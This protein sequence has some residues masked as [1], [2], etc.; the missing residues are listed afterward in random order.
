MSTQDQPEA[1]PTAGRRRR[2]LI[3]VAVVLLAPVL[4]TVGVLA[5]LNERSGV[6]SGLQTGD[7]AAVN[8]IEVQATVQKVDAATRFAQLRVEVIPHGVY[9]DGASAIPVKA[10]HLYTSSPTRGQLTFPAGQA[11]AAQDVTIGLFDGTF[12]DYPFDR[13]TA[14]IAF[15][16]DADGVTAPV[17]VVVDDIDPFFR[18]RAKKPVNEQ[19]VAGIDERVKR[20][21]GTVLL[22]VFMMVAMWA[23]ALAVAG[24]AW[25]LVSQRRGLVWPALG[26]MAATLFALVGMRNA[27]PGNPPVGCL[28]DYAAFFWAELL[29]AVSVVAVAARGIIVERKVSVV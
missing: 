29:V 15:A 20:S 9:A 12:S 24:A 17:S 27:A 28:L 10:L 22:A 16:A 19:D 18:L 7:A 3:W 4:C 11:I 23:L 26:W 8:R 5:Y 13:Y 2:V 1:S 14:T 25:I 21:R 6:E